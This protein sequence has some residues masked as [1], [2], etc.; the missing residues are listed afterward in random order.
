MI[1]EEWVQKYDYKLEELY[2]YIQDYV[3]NDLNESNILDL[4]DKESFYR[5][6]YNNSR[7]LFY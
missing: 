6:L 3:N 4:C 2:Y 5:F 7:E 1:Y